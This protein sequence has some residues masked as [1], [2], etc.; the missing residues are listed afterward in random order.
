M[1]VQMDD[2]AKH[3]ALLSELRDIKA[4]ISGWAFFIAILIGIGLFLLK[5]GG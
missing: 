4:T 5:Q 3:G 2:D 1:G